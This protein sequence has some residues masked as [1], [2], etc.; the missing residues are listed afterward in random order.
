MDSRIW[1]RPFKAKENRLPGISTVFVIA[2]FPQRHQ[3]RIVAR[4]NF[5]I[6]SQSYLMLSNDVTDDIY[7]SFV[8]N[9]L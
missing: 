6:L 8:F 9:L 1:V 2:F 5:F 4:N 3:I 7:E